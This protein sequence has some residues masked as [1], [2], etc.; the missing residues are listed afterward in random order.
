MDFGW[1]DEEQAFR[2]TVRA[3]IAEH[4][5]DADL[6]AIPDEDR[7]GMAR[8]REYGQQLAESGWLTHA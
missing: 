5:R 2:A 6:E 3:F 4:W 8:F 1:S 7:P